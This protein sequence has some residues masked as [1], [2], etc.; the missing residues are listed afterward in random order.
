MGLQGRRQTGVGGTNILRQTGA[1]GC[2]RGRGRGA[3]YFVNSNSIIV[4]ELR[5]VIVV[6]RSL[7]ILSLLEFLL[8][9]LILNPLPLFL[10]PRP[11]LRLPLLPLSLLPLAL[12]LRQP[13]L[14]PFLLT[15]A[16][17]LMLLLSPGRLPVVRDLESDD[18]C[19]GVF[20][21][22]SR[23]VVNRYLLFQV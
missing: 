20:L 7:A 22:I 10:L 9:L 4:F 16:F 3:V 2:P 17:E 23:C 12:L 13:R 21:G 18:R 8:L 5:S 11:V 6:E 19:F 15:S 14:L 1:R